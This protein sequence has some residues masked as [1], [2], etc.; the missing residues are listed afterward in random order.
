MALR[1]HHDCYA[2]TFTLQVQR[3]K[4]KSRR[5]DHV[6]VSTSATFSEV[7]YRLASAIG[8]F[9]NIHIKCNHCGGV[10]T[11]DIPLRL[12]TYHI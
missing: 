10:C 7:A 11:A 5:R 2:P 9:E 6:G 1:G 3:V 8:L 12:G 4:R